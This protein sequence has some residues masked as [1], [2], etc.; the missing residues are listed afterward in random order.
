MSPAHCESIE[1]TPVQKLVEELKADPSSHHVLAVSKVD[2]SDSGWESAYDAFEE[3][4]KTRAREITGHMGE[5]V[6]EG[7]WTSNN[8][9][10]WAM[11]QEITVWNLTEDVKLY[12][13]ID[14]EEDDMPII[15][16]M[17]TSESGGGF[18]VEGESPY[19]AMRAYL[20]SQGEL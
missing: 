16:A 17:G 19:K 6:W 11:G 9:P 12:L 4:Y 13:R 20:K 3:L 18:N 2:L 1:E 5:P 15:I 8:F 10:N 14:Q 7:D